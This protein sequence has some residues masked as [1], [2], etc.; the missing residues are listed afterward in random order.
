MDVYA[1]TRF[2]VSAEKAPLTYRWEG[3]GLNLHVP[4]GTSASFS[5][6][7]VWSSDFE[8]PEGTELVS[9]VYLVSCEGEVGGAVGVELQHCAQVN[10]EDQNSGLD[11]V[12]C[13]V[14]KEKPPYQFEVCRGQFSNASSFGRVEVK[15]SSKFLAIIRWIAG[16]G[17]SQVPQAAPTFLAKLYYQQQQQQSNTTVHFVIVPKLDMLTKVKKK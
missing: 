6:K 14:E 1:E 15:F 5:I 11:F 12:V 3:N 2:V 7:A 8:L 13:K 16:W 17:P 4:E 10:Q 9:P